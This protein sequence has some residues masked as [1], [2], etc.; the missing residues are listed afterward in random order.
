LSI[1]FGII[2]HWIEALM[3]R[4]VAPTFIQSWR[5]SGG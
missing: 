3:A 1:R 2:S 5:E 4:D